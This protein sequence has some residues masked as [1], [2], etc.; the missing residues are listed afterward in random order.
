MAV[1]SWL[2]PLSSL[3]FVAS[4]WGCSSS[5]DTSGASLPTTC[6]GPGCSSGGSS[7]LGGAA[8]GIIS[9]PDAG[10]VTTTWS[11]LCGAQ[12]AGCLPD[13]DAGSCDDLTNTGATSDE[14]DAGADASDASASDTSSALT[15]RIRSV[16]DAIVRVC[17][18]A[19]SGGVG[20]PCTMPADCGVGLTCVMEGS[21]GL[22]RPYCCAGPEACP[23]NTYCTSGTTLVSRDID[24]NTSNLGSEVPVCAAAE[25]CPLTDQ[26]PC[27]QGTSCTCP[28]GKACMI[29]R[30]HGLTACVKPGSGTQGQICP[31]A[32]GFVCSNTTFTC[33]KLCQLTSNVNYQ[34]AALQCASGNTC[35]A[36]N[37][38]PADWGVC[39]D[40]PLIMN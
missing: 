25:N 21:A 14:S 23:S 7:G 2:R 36:S 35:Q 5:S 40:L 6:Y 1:T 17:E 24:K 15:C 28:T 37:D 19:G 38:V 39:N 34:V 4:L 8:S 20:A 16:S 13:S 27:P 22:C 26:Y 30:R 3:V 31:C 18:L 29:V 12:A 32:A 33:L 10:V 11:P 9:P